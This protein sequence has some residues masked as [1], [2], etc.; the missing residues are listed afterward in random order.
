MPEMDSAFPFIAPPHDPPNAFSCRE[1][2]ANGYWPTPNR[3]R[4]WHVVQR[5]VML[6]NRFKIC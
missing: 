3:Y 2:K 1:P 4:S 6:D 5:A